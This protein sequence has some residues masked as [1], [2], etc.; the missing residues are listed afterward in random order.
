MSVARRGAR[1]SEIRR[2]HP[3]VAK[4]LILAA[5][6][7]VLIAAALFSLF[8]GA[9]AFA[10]APPQTS[11]DPGPTDTLRA[12]D[13]AI[14]RLSLPASDYRAVLSDALDDLPADDHG[15]A[16]A[17]EMRAFLARAPE[18]GA[19]FRC[20]PDFIADRARHM[21]VRLGDTLRNEYVARLE[22]AVCS[23]TPYALDVAHARATGG[24]LDI[25]G[26]DFD[27]VSPEMVLVTKSGYRDVTASL[28]RRSPYHLVFKLDEHLPWSADMVSLGL[29]WGHLIHHSIALV[30]P[31][32]EL[33]PSRIETL[34]ERT[35]SFSPPRISGNRLPRQHER[36]VTADAVL[37]Y[38]SNKLEATVCMAAADP[39][40]RSNALGGCSIEFLHTT[41]PDWIIEAILGDA[42]ADV[43][44]VR[45]AAKSDVRKGTGSGL[46]GQWTFGGFTG[47]TAGQ[48]AS[49]DIRLNA[50]KFLASA[51]QACV[52]PMAYLEARRTGAIDAATQQSIDRQ[53]KT[54]DPAVLTLRPRF[55]LIAG[56][57]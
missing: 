41:D 44:Y 51:D 11:R 28:E 7:R 3:N 6:A 55:V 38:S 37:N 15:I 53:I 12:I 57:K 30:Q 32:S 14:H 26:Y 34:P 9:S 52:S 56:A 31:T 18:P 22:P 43:S 27:R 33:C 21:L 23:T 40:G 19:E 42:S 36:Q 46:V 1:R 47:A 49:V 29:T 8:I 13:R 39:D 54:I 20:S 50:I 45:G 48:E 4:L 25:Y 5:A 24:W 17:G 16:A 35:I 10:A 2:P